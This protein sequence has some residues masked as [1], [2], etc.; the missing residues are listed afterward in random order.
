MRCVNPAPLRQMSAPAPTP[1]SAPSP[2]NLQ[3]L[4]TDLIVSIVKA[5]ARNVGA[6][7]LIVYTPWIARLFLGPTALADD[8]DGFRIICER[9]G[10]QRSAAWPTWKATVK[11]LK[12]EVADAGAEGVRMS[13]HLDSS[14]CDVRTFVWLCRRGHTLLVESRLSRGTLAQVDAVQPFNEPAFEAE[15]MGM[16]ALMAA[17]R[18]G[19]VEVALRLLAH[20]ANVDASNVEGYS[21]LMTA[22][23][24]AQTGVARLLLQRGATVDA[25]EDGGFTALIIAAE[26]GPSELVELLL[27]KGA[28]VSKK[29]NQRRSAL[30][31][32]AQVGRR[33]LVALLLQHGADVNVV[34]LDGMTPLMVSAQ[35]N[36][37]PVVRLLLEH[38][39]ATDT[40]N[41]DYETAVDFASANGNSRIVALLERAAE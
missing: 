34:G 8:G 37:E 7:T 11:E 26:G 1:A 33:D 31:A 5:W 23:L 9:F 15:V 12:H 13:T 24:H 10:V 19:H 28:S 17:A 4:P 39:A 41:D 29:T 20:G 3:D 21:P 25:A 40:Q 6:W 27:E 22:A 30:M 14:P 18:N 2:R 35:G 32:A 16:T 36:H 38:G